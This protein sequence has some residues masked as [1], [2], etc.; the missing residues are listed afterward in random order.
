MG[1]ATTLLIAVAGLA[2]LQDPQDPISQLIKDLDGDEYSVREEATARLI[3]LGKPA[4]PAVR[5]AAQESSSEEVKTRAER[6]LD[7]YV[8][9]QA[10]SL[11]ES[12]LPQGQS[13][14]VALKFLK[15]KEQEIE[16]FLPGYRFY[17]VSLPDQEAAI[18]GVFLG[19]DNIVRDYALKEDGKSAETALLR[20]IKKAGVTVKNREDATKF[21]VLWLVL[22][23]GS[24][25]FFKVESTDHQNETR[26]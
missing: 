26:Y 16:R 13:A 3:K 8:R 24:E 2:L 12:K 14:K 22:A 11:Y 5:Q 19:A 18:G 15:C 7:E 9:L 6:I 17:L 4:L 20:E 1:K 10:K 25:D 21:G 23:Y